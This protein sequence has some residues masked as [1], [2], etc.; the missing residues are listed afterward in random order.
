MYGLQRHQYVLW[1]EERKLLIWAAEA[2]ATAR[3]QQQQQT[4]LFVGKCAPESWEY[5]TSTVDGTNN[6]EY[7]NDISTELFNCSRNFE[8]VKLETIR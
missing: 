6:S 3:Q 8:Y 7:F 5:P 4:Q 2:A 1:D